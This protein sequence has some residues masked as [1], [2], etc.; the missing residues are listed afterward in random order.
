[1]I[2]SR[3]IELNFV[4]FYGEFLVQLKSWTLFI[5][6]LQATEKWTMILNCDVSHDT[7]L[8]NISDCC[9]I[10]PETVIITTENVIFHKQN[11]QKIPT[12]KL[13]SLTICWLWGGRWTLNIYDGF[14]WKIENASIKTPAKLKYQSIFFLVWL[15]NWPIIWY[16]VYSNADLNEK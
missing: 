15:Q 7:Y 4:T 1:M 6:Q 16:R 3:S 2:V 5:W 10:P 13:I 9:F 12:M 8:Y 11:D 14:N